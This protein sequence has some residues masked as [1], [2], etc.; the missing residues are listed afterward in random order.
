MRAD[1]LAVVRVFDGAQVPRL[2]N[3]GSGAAIQPIVNN[4]ALNAR[5]VK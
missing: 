2:A 3:G 5:Y 4:F 1:L